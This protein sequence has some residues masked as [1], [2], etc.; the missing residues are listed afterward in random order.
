MASHRFSEKN[1]EK[2]IELVQEHPSLYDASR[3]DVGMLPAHHVSS[4]YRGPTS[5][6]H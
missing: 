4:K 3:S 5:G 6:V 2:L 1:I